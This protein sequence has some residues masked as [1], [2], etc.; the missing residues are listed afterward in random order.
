VTLRSLGFPVITANSHLAPGRACRRSRD[1]SAGCTVEGRYRRDPSTLDETL[2]VGHTALRNRLAAGKSQPAHRKSSKGIREAVSGWGRCVRSRGER[3]PTRAP[4]CTQG[5]SIMTAS[6]TFDVFPASTATAPTAAAGGAATG[7]ARPRAAG[8]PPRLVRRGAADGLRGQHL[9]AIRATLASST[10]ES[11][12]RDPWVTRMRNLP[13]TVV[14]TMLQGPLDWPD[15]T[16]VSGDA[17]DVVAR[18]KEESEPDI[19]TGLM[20]AMV[21]RL[22]DHLLDSSVVRRADRSRTSRRRGPARPGGG[23]VDRAPACVGGFDEF[24]G[25]RHAG[26]AGS[27]VPSRPGCGA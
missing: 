18:L 24:E 10:V 22:A 25:H 8:L 12:V 11:E 3:P 21:T 17:V 14:S 19:P 13:A 9:S 6:Y 20:A 27:G 26:G 1:T 4:H 16:V 2:S 7:Q 23:G 15:A 5:E